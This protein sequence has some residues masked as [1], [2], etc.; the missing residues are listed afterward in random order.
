MNPVPATR[1][2]AGT[3]CAEAEWISARARL[4]LEK[5]GVLTIAE[6]VTHYPRRHEDRRRFDAFPDGET[7]LPVCLCG[8]VTKMTQKRFG[9][10]KSMLEVVLREDVGLGASLTCRWFN[11]HYIQKMIL[12]DQRL[13]VFGKPKRRGKTTVMDHPE[14]EVVEDSSETSIHFDRIVPVHSAGEGLQPRAIRE[15]VFRALQEIDPASLPELLPADPARIPRHAALTTLHFPESAESLQGIRRQLALEEFFGMQLVIQARRRRIADRPGLARRSPGKLLQQLR[16]TLPFSLTAGQEQAL[17]EI[18]AD[19]E[20]TRPMHRLLQGDVGSG[21]TVVALAAMLLAV[22]S[23]AQAAIMA[24]TQILAIQHFETFRRFLEPLALRIS[25]RTSDRR[26]E[27]GMELWTGGGDP[28]VVVGTHA[29]LFDATAFENLG[30]AVIDEQHK[31]GVMQRAALLAR[32]DAPDLLVMTATPIPR[33]LALT[34]YGDLDVSTLRERP[35]G[36]GKIVTAVR[37]EAKVPEAADFLREHLVAGRQVYIVYPLIEESEKLDAKAAQ[38]EFERW[39]VLLAPFRCELLHGRT[40]P[41]EKQAIMERFRANETKVLV[42]TTVI[43]VGVDVPNATIM[44][45][46]NAE[47]F[48]LAQL[49]QLRGRVGRGAHKSFCILLV[50]TKSF[51]TREKLSI[52]EKSSD[53]FE[54]AEADLRWR[55]AGDMLGTAQSGLPPIRIGDLF[56]DGDLMDEARRMAAEILEADSNLRAP[57]NAARRA[58][59]QSQEERLSRTG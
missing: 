51:A 12:V 19:L 59:L 47:R 43:E 27:E 6:L 33:T 38:E 53:G 2:P 29:L 25:L 36:R 15:L 11:S 5:L 49:H 4:S 13:V 24:P 1:L 31:F 18:R 14:F 41:D 40:H 46:E 17:E 52:L 30:L 55:G 57:E 10:W 34:L 3:P 58:F 8:T 44:L 45:V 48:G 22:E 42:S 32:G 9:G 56:R 35:A 23:G 54:I 28:H 37:D 21:K 39:K 7:D 50:G 26:A 16:A 20:S